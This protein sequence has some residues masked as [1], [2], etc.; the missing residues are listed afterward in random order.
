M[1]NLS[2]NSRLRIEASGADFRCDSPICGYLEKGIY[3][4]NFDPVLKIWTYTLMNPLFYELEKNLAA[5]T[6]P[7]L[8]PLDSAAMGI[9][10]PDGLPALFS[11]LPNEELHGSAVVPASCVQAIKQRLAWL[12]GQAIALGVQLP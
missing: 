5:L 10:D 12:T 9:P 4:M 1:R 7:T 2:I 11:P 8:D 3:R 6:A